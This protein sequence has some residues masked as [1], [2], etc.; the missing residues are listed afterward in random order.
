MALARGLVTV[1]TRDTA[2]VVPASVSGKASSG[3]GV[4]TGSASA[5]PLPLSVTVGA[6]GVLL[7]LEDTVTVAVRGPMAAGAKAS[8]TVQDAAGATGVVVVQVPLRVKSPAAAPLMA[9]LLNASAAVPVLRTVKLC[10]LVAPSDTL[11]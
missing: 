8:T 10:V 3:S 9:M 11:P 5:T 6:G 4:S 2:L 1:N 7:A